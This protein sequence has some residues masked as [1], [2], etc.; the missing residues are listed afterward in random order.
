MSQCTIGEIERG[1]G[2]TGATEG[3]VLVKGHHD[4]LG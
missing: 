1:T 3:N 4:A 2:E